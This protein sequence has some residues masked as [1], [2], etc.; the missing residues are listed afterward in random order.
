MRRPRAPI[1]NIN[2]ITTIATPNTAPPKRVSQSSGV[3]RLPP[4][5]ASY[6][7]VHTIVPTAMPTATA[8]NQP[9]W[10]RDAVWARKSI[11]RPHNITP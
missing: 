6:M 8:S 3:A 10:W 4:K 2:E 11:I 7:V 5:I 9:N 1:T